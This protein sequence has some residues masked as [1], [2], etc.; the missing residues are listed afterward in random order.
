M[1]LIHVFY[2]SLVYAGIRFQVIQ[3]YNNVSLFQITGLTSWAKNVG[4]I[5]QSEIRRNCKK[6][7]NK[8]SL[9]LPI[10]E[11]FICV[12]PDWYATWNEFNLIRHLL[13]CKNWTW[14]MDQGR[15]YISDTM[16]HI[17]LTVK[18]VYHVTKIHVL[19]NVYYMLLHGL[20]YFSICFKL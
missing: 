19:I 3:P 1:L 6:G 11:R 9:H 4:A 17:F 15:S 18:T 2:N 20:L 7:V 13:G 8:W 16:M 12:R 14:Y 10:M 5:Y